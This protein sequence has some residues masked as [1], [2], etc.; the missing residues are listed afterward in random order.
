MIKLSMVV[1]KERIPLIRA[2]IRLV[3]FVGRMMPDFYWVHIEWLKNSFL[4]R[5]I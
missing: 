3:P 5:W 1:F 4:Y 2:T